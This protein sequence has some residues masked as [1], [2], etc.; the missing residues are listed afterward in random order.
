MKDRVQAASSPIG[1]WSR[2]ALEAM[3]GS[4]V[5]GTEEM[6]GGRDAPDGEINGGGETNK[7]QASHPRLLAATTAH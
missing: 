2:P 5:A 7:A 6:C 1:P 4:H 3:M